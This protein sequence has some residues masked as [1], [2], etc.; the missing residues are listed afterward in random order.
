MR[1][2]ASEWQ[3]RNT[4]FGDLAIR[5]KHNWLGNDQ[6]VPMSLATVGFVRLPTGGATGQGAA[7]Y[8][9]IV[10]LNLEL[11]EKLTLD[12]QAEADLNY[13][14]K[15]AQ[16]YWRL[17]PSAAV[18]YEFTKKLSL[19]VEGVSQWQ[20]LD[21]QWQSSL[22]VAPILS[23]TDNFQVDFGAHLALDRRIDHEYFLGFTL[24]R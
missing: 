20:T 10:P 12:A 19:L 9:L 14:R 24:R 7:K 21:H 23:L 4:G 2:D 1:T 15:E 18:E 13:D 6:K 5:L 22:N 16:R 8:G 11:S 3:D 17:A